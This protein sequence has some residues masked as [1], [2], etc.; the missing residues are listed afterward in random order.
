[1]RAAAA[2]VLLPVMLLAGAACGGDDDDDGS[3]REGDAAAAVAAYFTQENAGG[4][5][6]EGPNMRPIGIESNALVALDAGD[7]EA[8]FCVPHGYLDPND[9]FA[10]HT[11]IYT[12]ALNDGA[13]AVEAVEETDTC[14]GVS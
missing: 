6:P 4:R 9:G 10:R 1:M 2:I 3:D 5:L 13:W 7:N 12:A 8:R 11:R 14:D